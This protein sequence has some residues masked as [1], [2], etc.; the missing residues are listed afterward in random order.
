MSIQ[1]IR[2]L[3][4][5]THWANQRILATSAKISEAQFTAPTAHSWGSL[6]GT[7]IHMLDTE[8]GWRMICQHDT[9]TDLLTRLICPP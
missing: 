9:E 5:Y 6:R 7:L 3:F 8:Y 1:D 4:D 2:T